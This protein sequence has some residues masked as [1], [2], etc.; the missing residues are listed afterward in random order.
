MYIYGVN[1]NKHCIGQRGKKSNDLK[2][3]WLLTLP[4]EKKKC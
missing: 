2:P 4:F 1:S 3:K